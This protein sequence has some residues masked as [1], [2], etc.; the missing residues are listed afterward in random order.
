M[1]KRWRE[2]LVNLDFII[3]GTMLAVLI[4]YTFF[5][6]IMRYFIRKPIIWGEEF[7]LF[8]IVIIVFFGAGAGFRTGSHVA[9]DIVVDRF[10]PKL[11]K[12]FEWL[13]YVIS[14]GV[15][16]YFTL[17]SAAFV[18]QMYATRRTTDILDIPHFITYSA[19]PLGCVFMMVNYTLTVL[20]KRFV[21][22]K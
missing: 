2:I 19:F 11:Q 14:M 13:I 15:F 5:G 22:E 9:I 17:Q 7:Q 16:I 3:S 4:L 10:P 12:I 6:V 20:R 1:N 18:R 21:K 8:C